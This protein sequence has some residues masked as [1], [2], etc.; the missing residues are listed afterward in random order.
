[1]AEHDQTAPRAADIAT[2]LAL[3][4][5]L[6]MPAADSEQSARAA[7]AY[8]LVGLA[9]GGL[10][11]VSAVVAM[12][13]GLPS[14]VA[15]GCVLAVQILVTGAMHEDGLADSADGLWGGWDRDRRLQIMRDSMIGTYGVLALILSLGLRWTALAGLFAAGHVAG[16]VLAA[17]VLSRAPMTALMHALPHA[18]DTG[19]SH[20]VGRPPRRA[21]LI[22]VA[23][24][25]A[26]ALISVGGSA[27]AAT[28]AVVLAGLA[29]AAIARTKIGGQTG[30]IL[31]ATQQCCEIAALATLAALLG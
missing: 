15:A 30:D 18:R 2:A 31:G 1:M 28:L 9:V 13:A 6:P 26:L 17:A 3:L 11:A 20:A 16:P 23:L 7:W 5:R 4:T 21:A 12:A 10:A 19:L 29:V 14:A 8:P 24:A 27:I 25:V 22:A